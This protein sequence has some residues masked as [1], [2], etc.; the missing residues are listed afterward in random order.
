MSD[1]IKHECGLA[2]VRLLKPLDYYIENYGTPT[3]GINKM[4]LLM[5]KQH[6]R[7]QDGA[8]L[9]NIKLD[10]K[11]GQRYINRQRSNA[12]QPIKN[13]FDQINAQFKDIHDRD[14][15][16]LSDSNW[17]KDNVDFTG[18]LFLGHLRYGTFG[19]NGIENC[20]PF[21]R[22]NNWM[23]KN[24]VVAGNFNLTNVDE[25]FNVL[26]GIGQHPKE[27]SDTV[28]ILEKIGHFLDE[29]N[30]ELFDQFKSQGHDQQQI[31]ELI[32]CNI[33]MQRILTKSAEKWDGGYAMA[34]LLGHGDAFVLRD[35]SGIR[36]AFYYQ[37]EEVVVVTSERPVIQTAFN[38]PI[39]SIHEIT[40]GHALLIK[41]DGH[42]EENLIR[43]PT[44][45]LPCS[46]E[47]IY[48]SRGSDKDVYEERKR[49]GKN[50][51]Q[52]V[53]EAIGDDLKNSVF[54][55]IP[56]TAEVS[57]FGMMKGLQERLNRFKLKKIQALGNN[58][59]TKEI[60]QILSLQNR[61]EKIAVKDAK[62]RTFIAQ[63]DGRDDLVTHIYD[64]TYG[65]VSP[66]DNLV[67]IDD[68]IVRGTTLKQSILRILDRLGP[69]RVVIASSCPQIRYPDC[70][71]IDM[72]KLGDF[73]AFQAAIDLLKERNMSSTIDEVYANCRQQE[74]L[75]K[76]DVYNA[77]KE[78]YKPFTT[79]EVSFKISQL[80]TP[81]NMRA[82]VRVVFQSID[83]LHQ[84]CPQHKGDWYFT[85]NYPTPGGNQVV[86]RAF[87]NY[88]EGK[89]RRAY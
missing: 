29:E 24:L 56:N 65:T 69:K 13:I 10:V 37:D 32:A 59:P 5:Q 78:I 74:N 7:G 83:G 22:Q 2:L 73:I 47:R 61:M 84:A 71:G 82:E 60:E 4:Y 15:S 35:P 21:L 28:T 36:P 49:L 89:N 9:A 26:V 66:T 6:N 41:K 75:Q 53:L 39:D 16:L 18:E 43:E 79:E 86:N 80:L 48:F 68:S 62:L 34:G 67:I 40:P 38:A 12:S 42:V 81:K 58:A 46:F 3:Y 54:S 72:A 14:P 77:V 76:R 31:S 57:F 11:P 55:Y 17:L 25:L 63:D 45:K 44:K 50:V 1:A 64:V 51:C 23:T 88:C 8:G 52:Q 27:K 20:H 33:N 85:G 87:I 19:N 70:Y 30:Q